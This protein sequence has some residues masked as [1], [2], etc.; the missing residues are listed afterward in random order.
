VHLP[1]IGKSQIKY[2]SNLK[3]FK[4]RFKLFSHR[5]ISDPRFPEISN[6][7]KANLK[8]FTEIIETQYVKSKYRYSEF[9]HRQSR[10]QIG[11]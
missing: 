5:P 8:S 11:Y 7:L 3:Y 9:M 6:L 4:K 10:T 1:V 2:H